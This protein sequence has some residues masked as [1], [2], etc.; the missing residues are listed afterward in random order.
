LMLT[1]DD[2]RYVLFVV[3]SKCRIHLPLW[4]APRSLAAV[5]A[6]SL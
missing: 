3:T 6:A 1:T 2:D 5:S 4:D